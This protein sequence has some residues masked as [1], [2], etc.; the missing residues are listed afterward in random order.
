MQDQG[1]QDQAVISGVFA[2]ME[3]DPDGWLAGLGAHWQKLAQAEP[4]PCQFP[5]QA[6]QSAGRKD[7][8]K[9]AVMAQKLAGCLAEQGRCR[10]VTQGTFPALAWGL[11][12]GMPCPVGWV[13]QNQV[14]LATIR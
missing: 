13:G 11:P 10:V 4:G 3:Q 12:P 6:G 2:G 9:M 14:K 8:D 7:T 5:Q 1:R